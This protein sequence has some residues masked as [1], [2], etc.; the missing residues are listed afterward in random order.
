MIIERLNCTF[1][2]LLFFECSDLFVF[3]VPLSLIYPSKMSCDEDEGDILDIIS[4]AEA[5]ERAE[6]ERLQR[7]E[8][9]ELADLVSAEEYLDLHKVQLLDYEKQMF[10]D[11]VHSDGLVIVGK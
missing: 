9:T 8:E 6:Q 5:A 7:E 1:D 11:L 10:L 4:S 2:I 3:F